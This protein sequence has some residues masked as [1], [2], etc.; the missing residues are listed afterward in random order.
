MKNLQQLEIRL[1]NLGNEYDEYFR[2]H[3]RRKNGKIYYDPGATIKL[4]QLQRNIDNTR[5]NINQVKM[6]LMN[7]R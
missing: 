4:K 5:L 3:V 1:I 6:S 2:C 7:K